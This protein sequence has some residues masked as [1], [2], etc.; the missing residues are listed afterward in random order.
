MES[1][2][3]TEL[4]S[5]QSTYFPATGMP[6]RDWWQALWPEPIKLLEALGLRA[7]MV[8]VDLC[9][10]DGYF[11]AP[12][13]RLV[14]PGR[15]VAV[16]LDPGML[17]QARAACRDHPNCTFLQADARELARL[18]PEPVDYVLMANTFHGV[19][20]K[21][22]LA[23]AAHAVLKLEGC[24]VVVNW[25]ARPREETPVLG[26]PRGPATAMRVSPEALRAVV[27]PAGFELERLAELPPYHY[28]AI[29]VQAVG[30]AG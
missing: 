22:G 25:H 24:F 13:A 21:T 5:K 10:G 23:R 26:Q 17:E 29:F 15:V 30:R 27:E 28:G 16:D 20:D 3:A 19:P 9:C 14:K 18:V 1:R 7:G 8:V 2:T 11:T 12:L 6:D 4:V